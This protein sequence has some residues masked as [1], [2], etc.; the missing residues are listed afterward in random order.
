MTQILNVP[1]NII[2]LSVEYGRSE[3]VW[4]C[5]LLTTTHWYRGKGS[6]MQSALDDAGM[7]LA[8]GIH[9]GINPPDP[10]PKKY[11]KRRKVDVDQKLSDLF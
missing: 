2:K 8:K 5:W 4:F 1:D 3:H 6:T 7:K 11:D 9:L 10:D